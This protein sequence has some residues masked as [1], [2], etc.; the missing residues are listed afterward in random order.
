MKNTKK[1]SPKS[2]KKKSIPKIIPETRENAK[3]TSQEGSESM[4]DSPPPPHYLHKMSP[5]QVVHPIPNKFVSVATFGSGGFACVDS[6]GRLW[7]RGLAS[8][9]WQLYD[10]TSV[11][12][13]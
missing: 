9:N 6:D 5:P 12:A 8:S 3:K 4:V 1:P 11:I 10:E 13:F 2:M 7:I